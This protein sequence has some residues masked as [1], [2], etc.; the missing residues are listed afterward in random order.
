MFT[1]CNNLVSISDNLEMLDKEA[2]KATCNDHSVKINFDVFN[3]YDFVTLDKKYKNIQLQKS[4]LETKMILVDS[5][6]KTRSYRN[7]Y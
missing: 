3:N 7:L 4:P 2:K 5:I 1:E 6:L